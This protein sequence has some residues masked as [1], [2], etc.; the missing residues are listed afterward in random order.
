MKEEHR[1]VQ[2]RDIAGMR[3]KIIHFYFGVNWDIVW[4]TVKDKMPQLKSKVENI[5]REMR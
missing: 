3:D 5:L 2:W 4:Q 1:E